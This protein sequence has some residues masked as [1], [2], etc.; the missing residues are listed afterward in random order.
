MTDLMRALRY[1][2]QDEGWLGYM[3]PLALLQLFPIVGQIILVGYGQAVAR[4]TY[5]QQGSLPRLQLRQAFVDGLRL[6]A[7]GLVYF[8][9]VILM[10]LLV[11][12][13]SD[14]AKTE[15]AVGAVGLILPLIMVVYMPLSSAIGKRHPALKPI[16]SVLSTIVGIVFALFIILRLRELFITTLRGGLQ[17]SALQP[18]ATNMPLLLVAALLLAFVTVALLVS[19]VQFAVTGGGLLNPNATLQLMVAKR[20]LT[21]R[22]VGIVWLLI[23]GTLTVA[24][25]GSLFLLLPGLLLLVSGSVS[26]WFLAAQYAMKIGVGPLLAR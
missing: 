7:V 4:A 14:P 3:L 6:V 15:T 17:L 2:W 8:L 23:A 16:L 9:P 22:F 1:P 24:M 18:N 20:S 26:I 12:S 5:S 13:S 10:V 25:I 11:L 19:G 21:G